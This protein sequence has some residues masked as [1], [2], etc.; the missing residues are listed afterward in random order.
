LIVPPQG[1]YLDPVGYDVGHGLRFPC[2]ANQNGVWTCH[3][4]IEVDWCM[5]YELPIG[6]PPTVLVC[7]YCAE[8]WYILRPSE[9]L[10]FRISNLPYELDAK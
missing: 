4:L 1:T 6:M 3:R 10:E 9:K 8:R 7:P 2:L 5:S